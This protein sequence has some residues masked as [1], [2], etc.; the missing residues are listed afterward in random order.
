MKAYI[1]ANQAWDTLNY[2]KTTEL[3]LEFYQGY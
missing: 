2:T 3:E 1:K